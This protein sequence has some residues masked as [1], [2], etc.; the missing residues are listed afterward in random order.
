M[1]SKVAFK[2]ASPS[3]VIERYH[4]VMQLGGVRDTLATEIETLIKLNLSWT[5]YFPSCSSQ[6]WQVEG[7]VQ[8]VGFEELVNLRDHRDGGGNPK[9]PFLSRN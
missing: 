8:A 2:N 1:G 6:P 4:E 7:V 9:M 3:T 5:L